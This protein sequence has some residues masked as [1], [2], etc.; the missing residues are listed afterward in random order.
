MNGDSFLT[1]QM[2]C[3]KQILQAL[4]DVLLFKCLIFP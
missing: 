1:N 2:T 3:D 4:I